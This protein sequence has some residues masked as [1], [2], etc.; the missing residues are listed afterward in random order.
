MDSLY[1]FLD[2]M[3]HLTSDESLSVPATKPSA[4]DTASVTGAN[5][6]NPLELLNFENPV[7]FVPP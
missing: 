4:A 5:G 6:T 2:G 3:V 1:A 7:R